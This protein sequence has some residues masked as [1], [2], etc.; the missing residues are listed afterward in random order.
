MKWQEILAGN[1]VSGDYR[2]SLVSWFGG[3]KYNVSFGKFSKID[4]KFEFL[5]LAQ[6]FARKHARCWRE[7]KWSK[8]DPGSWVS[9]CGHYHA[10][11]EGRDWSLSFE[12]DFVKWFGKLGDAQFFAQADSLDRALDADEVSETNEITATIESEVAA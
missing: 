3:N 7:L 9:D 1:W 4:W 12:H 8:Q 5:H 10:R 2:I 11:R 6:A